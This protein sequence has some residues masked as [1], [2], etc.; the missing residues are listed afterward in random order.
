[1]SRKDQILTEAATFVSTNWKTSIPSVL[2]E[3]FE[4]GAKWADSHPISSTEKD[5]V[6]VR[7]RNCAE[8]DLTIVREMTKEE[9]DF[10]SDIA[11]DLNYEGQEYTPMLCVDILENE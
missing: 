2:I 5:K 1:M 11:Q 4:E 6:K 9:Y 8:D 7:I 3:C 10:L